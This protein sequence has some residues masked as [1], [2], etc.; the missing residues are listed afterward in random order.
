MDE[1]DKTREPALVFEPSSS[2]YTRNQNLMSQSAP[3]NQ[4]RQDALGGQFEEPPPP[5]QGLGREDVNAKDDNLQSFRRND[6]LS[7]QD[8]SV[9]GVGHEAEQATGSST[10]E[11]PAR[12]GHVSHVHLTLSPKATDHS[13]A[14][15]V[16]S[17]HA[18]AVTGL[19]RKEFVPLRHSS[20]AASSPDEGV[21]LSSPPEWYDNREPIREPGPGRA[22]TSTLFKTAVLQGRKTSTSHRVVV[23]PRPSTTETPGRLE[24]KCTYIIYV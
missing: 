20:S 24:M 4:K 15:A 5:S 3:G 10:S 18:D 14:A 21:G 12:T 17:S 16:H 9:S 8:S 1:D 6:E 11:S 2:L 23:S 13:L 7:V 19:P 22:D